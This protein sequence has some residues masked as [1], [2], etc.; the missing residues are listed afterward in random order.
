MSH[1]S[2]EK[3]ANHS[4]GPFAWIVAA[5]FSCVGAPATVAAEA[6][7]DSAAMIAEIQALRA[8]QQR[9]TELQQQ[10]EMKLRTLEA[11]L[12][13]ATPSASPPASPTSPVPAVAVAD[14]AAKSRLVVSGDLRVR[15][16]GDYAEGANDRLSG[17][18]RGRLG[19]TFA[20]NDRVTI[21][22]RLVTGNPD[23]P[24]STDV[25]L[26]NFDDDLEVSLD[27]AYVQLNLGD[28]KVYGGKIPQPF[29][30]TELVWDGDVNP[31][32]LSAVYRHANA[33]GSAFRANSLFFIVDESAASDSTML[34]VQFGYDTRALG[35]WKLDAS[36]AYYDYKL[37]SVAGGDS[38]DF[39]SNPRNPDGTYVSDFELG[40]AIIGA[41]WSGAGDRWPLR[42]VGDY[43]H[44]FGAA[45]DADTGYG[46]DLTIGRASK[47]HDWRVTYGYSVAE[48][49]AVLAAFSHD[50]IALGTNYRLH[51][52][53]LDYVPFPK[54]MLTAYW[55]HYQPY[56]VAPTLNSDWIERFRL[57]FTVSF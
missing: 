9:I 50:N 7:A 11:S 27:Q 54:T 26:S 44:N 30:R 8:E 28:L 40:D 43:V 36:V 34:G 57:A 37:G 39:R 16:Q 56:D 47:A 29:T 51:A 41:T 48:T 14:A 42:L 10:V 5:A 33:D 38:G 53:T 6:P 25:Q 2:R 35:N 55:Y 45:T 3:T 4:G 21:G 32:G 46:A 12:H 52:L 18:V 19:A 15:T 24:N 20:A 23:D 49:D 17:Q 1:M 13:Q 22:A 31:Q